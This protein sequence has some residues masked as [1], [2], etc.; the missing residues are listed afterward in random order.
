[1]I[2][3]AMFFALGALTAGLLMLLIGPAVWR[4]AV[5]LTRRA[6][7]ATTPMSLA[8]VHAARDQLRAEYAVETRRL[9]LARTALSDKVVRQ[10][11]EISGSREAAKSIALDLSEKLK[12]IDEAEA[13]ETALRAE[14]RHNETELARVSARLRETEMDLKR[15]S[16]QFVE[17]SQKLTRDAVTSAEN[18]GGEFPELA[19]MEAEIAA[20]K[21]RRS[22]DEAK[23]LALESELSQLRRRYAALEDARIGMTAAPGR[24]APASNAVMQK[25]EGLVIDLEGR[26]VESQAE[27]TR[28]SLQLESLRGNGGDN[29]E[30]ALVSLEAENNALAEE[31]NRT[32]VERG[33][34]ESQLKK[35]A[36]AEDR[37][38]SALREQITQL[39]AQFAAMTADKE[40]AG[41][42]I[43]KIL[44]D[45]EEAQGGAQQ[46]AN[47]PSGRPGS[48]AD[49]IRGLRKPADEPKPAAQSR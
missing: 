22:A 45:A 10:Q 29:M 42:A 41:S 33:R 24:T 34:L 49:R 16:Q 31:L 6:V 1:M 7:E 32:A 35:L 18:A 23:I 38:N 43:D 17:L 20:Q 30:G 47:G 27:I 21:T 8:E 19:V 4:R 25:L 14:L 12:I 3:A 36:Q 40:G 13:R 2:N 37:E 9:E 39:A 26:N 44:T 28:L 5:R 46:R 48:L 11:V 15:R